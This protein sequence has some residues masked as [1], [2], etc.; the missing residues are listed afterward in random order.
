MRLSEHDA[1]ARRRVCVVVIVCPFLLNCICFIEPRLVVIQEDP[2]QLPCN[3]TPSECAAGGDAT[4]EADHAG[5]GSDAV[6]KSRKP[7]SQVWN[8]SVRGIIARRTS[9]SVLSANCVIWN[10]PTQTRPTCTTTW[11][12]SMAVTTC[13]T[14]RPV[15]R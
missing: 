13:K 11:C 5:E 3:G 9:E 2:Q 4:V 7:V 8:F 15:Q 6:L 1:I 10:S 12:V 14:W